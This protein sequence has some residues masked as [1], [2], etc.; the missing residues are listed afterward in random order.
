MV[1][2]PP[3]TEP[4]QTQAFRPSAPAHQT[5]TAKPTTPV[6]CRVLVIDDTPAIHDDFRK[7]LEP[8]EDAALAE[9]EAAVF[10]EDGK[11]VAPLAFEV[12]C[13]LQG[14]DG[15][16][17]IER[18]L[19]EVRPYAVAFVDVRMPPGWD[20]IETIGH[21][22]KADPDL[23]IVICTAY[24]DYSWNDIVAKLGHSDSLLVLK[25]PF[26]TIEVLQLASALGRKWQLTRAAK[27]RLQLLDE[28]VAKRTE[29]LRAANAALRKEAAERSRVEEQLRQSQKLEAVGQLAG[30]VAH[31]F[32]N[33]LAVIRGNT[34]LVMIKCP[35]LLPEVKESL[36]QIA[37]ASDRAA[38]LTRQLLAFSRKQ[39]MRSEHLNLNEVVKNL[40]K[41]LK[42]IIGEHIQLECN[43]GPSLPAVYGDVGMLEQVLLNLV[44][45]SRDAMPNGGKVVLSTESRAISAEYGLEHPEARAGKFVLLTVT[46]SGC[47]IAPENL[48]HIFEPFFT[49]KQIGKGTGLGLSTV[50]GIVKQH[51][52]WIEVSSE[53]GRGA[54]F[55]IALPACDTPGAGSSAGTEQ[56][57]P[58]G[59]TETI[60]LVEDDEALRHLTRRLLEH[61]GYK[62]IEANC[63]RK[64]LELYNAEPLELDL[65]L[66]DIIMPGGMT[67]RELADELR[68]RCKKIRVI[69]TSGYSG[70]V[71]GDE[72][73]YLRRTKSRFLSK[74]CSPSTLLRAIRD[75]LEST[76]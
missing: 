6:V 34:D 56:S 42:R 25:K 57:K 24:S 26:D 14:R 46:D 68:G 76:G 47:G 37:A 15:L 73:A 16:G 35:T 22:W 53:P 1:Q 13:A 69:F 28:A 4:N 61:Y 17:K 66:T 2:T 59:G 18:G 48:A 75:A 51:E 41:M 74:P 21:L 23:Q 32:N 64:A 70:D 44:V 20:G 8:C 40:S 12:E 45:N 72:T 19:R 38:N 29:E 60:L 11:A 63:A 9:T 52:G 43:Y 49:T 67:G 31:D 7:V 33:L 10:G 3:T 50:Y 30:G 5:D 39:M 71:L 62:V 65:L 27:E 54:T 55:T 58:T 36:K